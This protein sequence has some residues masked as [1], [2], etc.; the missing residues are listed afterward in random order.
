MPK[1]KEPSPNTRCLVT[2]EKRRSQ[3]VHIKNTGSQE[4]FESL[5]KSHVTRI[6][7]TN[8]LA[9]LEKKNR[10]SAKVSGIK[11]LNRHL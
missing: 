1:T 8:G 10:C 4:K 11:T 9:Q 5:R 6:R 3:N 2:P 7:L